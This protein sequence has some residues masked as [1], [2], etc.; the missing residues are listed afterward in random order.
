[1]LPVWSAYKNKKAFEVRACLGK[2]PHEHVFDIERLATHLGLSLWN[3]TPKNPDEGSFLSYDGTNSPKIC[4]SRDM[5]FRWQRWHIALQTAYVLLYLEP[6][7]AQQPARLKIEEIETLQDEVNKAQN[8]AMK[9]LMPPD[10]FRDL[11]MTL[12]GNEF[13]LSD[14]YGVPEK[15]YIIRANQIFGGDI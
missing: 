12:D 11:Y 7:A 10:S 8:Y 13:V 1:M 3:Y 15:V 2:T 4:V 9:L 6:G 14:L 5:D